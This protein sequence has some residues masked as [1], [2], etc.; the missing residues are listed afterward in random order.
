MN[1]LPYV[2]LVD[3]RF[4]N[5]TDLLSVFVLVDVVLAGLD[6]EGAVAGNGVDAVASG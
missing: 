2:V 6:G 3:E 5:N 4:C 1:F